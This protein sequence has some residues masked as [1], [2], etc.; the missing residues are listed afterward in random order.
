MRSTKIKIGVACAASAVVALMLTTWA[1]GAGP[2]G[3]GTASATQVGVRHGY[4][5]EGDRC[6][7]QA[8]RDRH[9]DP[10]R[11]LHDG[12]QVRRRVLRLRERQR[13]HQ[14]PPDQVHALQRAA[15]PD[16]GGGARQ[17]ADRER[18]G[19]RRRRQHELRRV[20]HQLAVLPVQG[21]HRDR[22]RRPGRVLRN[23]ELR[24]GR[25]WARATATSARPRR[26][27]SAGAKSLVV[28]SPD[29]ISAYADGGVVKVAAGRRA[30]RS[31]VFPTKLPVTDANSTILQAGAGRRHGR[32]RH[33]RLHAG[34]GAGPAAGGG[35]A[36]P[37]RQG[38]VG[39]VD[40]DRQH[41]HGGAGPGVRRQD[42]HQLRSSA[43][44]RRRARTRRCTTRSTR[45][46]R[47]RSPSRASA[48]W[49]SWTG[50]SRRRRSSASRA[51]SPRSRT[52]ARSGRSRTS[53]RTCSASPGTSARISRTTSRTTR[54]SRSTTR[55]AQVVP[56]EKCFAIAGG[57][58]A[59][60]PDPR[61][62]EEVPAE[63]S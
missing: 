45:S 59:D 36:G 21:L 63:G 15:Q 52:T 6:A 9:A 43:A 55:P 57:R 33:P 60:R 23:A 35:R 30:S 47:R 12:R 46:T 27:S 53:R 54:T 8:R 62:G 3:S 16:A 13:R 10:G 49:A 40:A 58:S 22:R 32:R 38:D 37:R 44:R 41:V 11:R 14:R 50:S 2:V 42:V 48:R 5:Q 20:R 56:K 61:L 31:K 51:R 18:Q 29:T 19:R 17:E 24:R 39:L 26:S 25:T 7:D 34:H 4:R 1:T 28:A